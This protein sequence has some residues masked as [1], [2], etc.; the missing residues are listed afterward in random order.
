MSSCSFFS[1]VFSSVVNM[2]ALA[3]AGTNLM[4][5]FSKKI[6]EKETVSNQSDRIFRRMFSIITTQNAHDTHTFDLKVNKL[7][8]PAFSLI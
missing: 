3:S 8:Y 5:S 6:K 1:L 4:L 2:P 7:K